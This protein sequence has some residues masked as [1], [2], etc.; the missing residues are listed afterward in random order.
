MADRM[1]PTIKNATGGG[2]SESS[3]N[4]RA[5]SVESG[6]HWLEYHLR[7][8]EHA[9][10]VISFVSGRAALDAVV[11]SLPPSARVVID[12]ETHPWAASML[13]AL[14]GPPNRPWSVIGI[15]SDIRFKWLPDTR[16]V[17]CSSPSDPLGHI[18]D[19]GSIGEQ[20][21]RD[22]A[23]IAVDASNNLFAQPRP[24]DHGADL[25]L[26]LHGGAIVGDAVEIGVVATN[27]TSWAEAL[28]AARRE[29][30]T[31][32]SPQQATDLLDRVTGAERRWEAQTAR[33]DEVARFLLQHDRVSHVHH[34]WGAASLVTFAIQP[35]RSVRHLL[36]AL[37]EFAGTADHRCEVSELTLQTGEHDGNIVEF[38]RCVVGT[39]DTDELISGLARALAA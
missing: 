24:L 21:A 29:G 35:G 33:A 16:L 19:I 38:V 13:S 32:P 25:T 22:G 12:P 6:V 9:E 15:D 20:V 28:L 7:Q 27:H 36:S 18:I 34:A 23:I 5:L 17:I 30:G 26:H 10:H 1:N 37:T 3:S 2:V 11:R 4:V 31:A 8:L 39:D 14:H